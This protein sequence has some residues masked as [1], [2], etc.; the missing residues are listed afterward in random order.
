M[1]NVT[2]DQSVTSP[3][4][5]AWLK[6]RERVLTIAKSTITPSGQ[7]IDWIPIESQVRGSI[8][9]PPPQLGAR[10]GRDADRP[11]A[12]AALEAHEPGP[13]DH[14]PVL[15]PNVA[16][17]RD[18][19]H[20]RRRHAKRGGLGV[21]INRPNRSPADPDPFGYFHASSSQWMSNWG[22]DAWLNVW[23]PA[24]DIPSSPGTDH[25]ISQTWVQS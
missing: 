6:E 15:R 3:D 22:A 17:L 1:S 12:M 19:E 8:A 11:T 9:E 5:A 2:V 14:V 7:T 25:S 20:L 10:P 16:S 13:A 24:I 21:N 23:D 4:V 18:L